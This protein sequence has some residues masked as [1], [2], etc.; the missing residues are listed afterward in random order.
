MQSKCLAHAAHMQDWNENDRSSWHNARWL[1]K[2]FQEF[3][4]WWAT[5]MLR[6]TFGSPRRRRTADRHHPAWDPIPHLLVLG[7]RDLQQLPDPSVRRPAA[8]LAD[9]RECDG[10]ARGLSSPYGYVDTPAAYNYGL[11]GAAG[12]LIGNLLVSAVFGS[13]E[14]RKARRANMRRCMNYKGYERYGLPKDTWQEFNFEEGLRKVDEKDRQQMLAQQA[15]A[16]SGPTPT[17]KALGR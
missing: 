4:L 16:A 3:P 17:G 11:A 1:G 10:Y 9:L 15:K 5:A 14:L 13:A 6:G 12:G 2:T 8:A 7:R